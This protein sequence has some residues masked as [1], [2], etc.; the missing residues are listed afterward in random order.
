M[1]KKSVRKEARCERER[2]IYLTSAA[3][4]RPLDRVFLVA[5]AALAAPV[6]H[7]GI[8]LSRLALGLITTYSYTELSRVPWGSLCQ[9]KIATRPV[10]N[11]QRDT[12][13]RVHSGKEI[14]TP[15]F[16]STFFLLFRTGWTGYPPVVLQFSCPSRLK[17][18]PIFFQF[19]FCFPSSPLKLRGS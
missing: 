3:A 6:P 11:F 17:S 16:S 1:R 15:S 18:A 5:R 14:E 12:Q 10:P 19:T 4:A 2:E 13:A 7:D 8:H 9:K